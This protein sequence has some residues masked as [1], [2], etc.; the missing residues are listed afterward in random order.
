MLIG[1]GGEAGEAERILRHAIEVAP[2]YH[3]LHFNLGSLLLRQKQ[4]QAA[5]AEF[6]EAIR[7]NPGYAS[8]EFSLGET[9]AIEKN[10]ASALPHFRRAREL[11]LSS[12]LL[13]KQEHP[14]LAGDPAYAELYR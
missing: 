12:G 7:R 2:F 13:L 8:S 6:Q 14:E 10:A 1:G 9:F 5:R 3:L 11:G 4:L